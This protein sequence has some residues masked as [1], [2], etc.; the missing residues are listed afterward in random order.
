MQTHSLFISEGIYSVQNNVNI[1]EP[2][3]EI[4]ELM[5]NLTNAY[6]IKHSNSVSSGNIN[7]FLQKNE[8][9]FTELKRISF[10]DKQG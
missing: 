10:P 3:V 2:A 4:N 8:V 5:H 9:L 1:P 7:V 6:F